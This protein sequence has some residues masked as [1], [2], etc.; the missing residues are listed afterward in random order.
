MAV[1]FMDSPE[2]YSTVSRVWTLGGG[3]SWSVTTVEGRRAIHCAGTG[4]D[5]FA[6]SPQLPSDA[7]YTWMGHVRTA[8]WHANPIVN[9]MEYTSGVHHI[10]WG[11][12]A[13]GAVR[14]TFG[15][16]GTQLAITADGVWTTSTT[17]WM[18]FQ[19][20]IHDTTGSF[21]LKMDGSTI[22]SASGIDTRNGG[23]GY[24]DRFCLIR[25]SGTG[26]TGDWQDVVA[27]SGTGGETGF[28]NELRVTYLY[29]D[30]SGNSTQ[31]TPS[32]GSNYQNVD[33]NPTDANDDTDYNSSSNNGDID[34]YSLSA[35]PTTPG[36]VYA[37][38]PV[39]RARMDDVGPQTMR[40]VIRTNSTNYEGDDLSLSAVYANF[41][42]TVYGVNPNTSSA[43]T[44][45]EIST[46]ECGVK[47]QA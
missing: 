25:S 11:L 15:N 14:V 13:A 19:A 45:S 17:H 38:A 40:T 41:R 29:P 9:F 47:K 28:L 7:T 31:F 4:T 26:S 33:D 43:W 44:E 36:T 30:G 21:V 8:A 16:N 37:V 2:Y 6:Y 23:S 27:V 1:T 32:A 46:L 12:S 5:A 39:V 34:L 22:L 18:E 3:G 35:L 10:G 24:I 42:N 20:T